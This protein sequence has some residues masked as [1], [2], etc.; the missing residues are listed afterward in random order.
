VVATTCNATLPVIAAGCDS[1]RL[2][3]VDGDDA[4]RA[5]V[6][7]WASTSWDV[8]RLLDNAMRLAAE[9]DP[10]RAVDQHLALF[11]ALGRGAPLSTRAASAAR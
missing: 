10:Q 9:H 8:T 11:D 3:P 5:G 7:E 4:F 1:L 6:T 2:A